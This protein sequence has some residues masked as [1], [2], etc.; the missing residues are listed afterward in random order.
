MDLSNNGWLRLA[1]LFSAVMAL[2]SAVRTIGDFLADLAG[3]GLR[4]S[5]A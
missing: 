2:I 1:A 4:W 3:G 5:A